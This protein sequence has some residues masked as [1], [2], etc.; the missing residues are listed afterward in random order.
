MRKRSLRNQLIV[1]MLL[2]SIVPLLLIAILSLS[3]FPGVLGEQ[4]SN[5]L[6][7]VREIK[8]KQLENY[9]QSIKYQS[10]YFV[11][12]QRAA[13][14]SPENTPVLSYIQD[15]GRAVALLFEENEQTALGQLFE[16]DKHSLSGLANSEFYYFVHEHLHPRIQPF[17]DKMG[18]N[19]IYLSSSSGLIIYAVTK[20]DYF[21][22][23]VSALAGHCCG[24]FNAFQQA[25]EHPVN[26]T[27]VEPIYFTDFSV[28]ENARQALSYISIPI[29]EYG[30][31]TGVIIYEIAL[32]DINAIMAE[33]SGLGHS[34]E[35]YLVA[36]DHSLRS[37]VVGKDHVNSVY[38]SLAKGS[39]IS[40]TSASI[41]AALAGQSDVQTSRSYAQQEVLSAYAPVK[42]FDAQWALV[43]DMPSVEAY[44]YIRSFKV[45]VILITTALGL[46]IVV[47][48]LSFA[49][50]I[51]N[52]ITTLT[53]WSE[54]IT[55]GDLSPTLGIQRDDELGRLA[56]SFTVMKEAIR[57][58]IAEI[59]SQNLALKQLDKLKDNILANTSH[60]LRTPLNAI[61][62]LAE[63][64][65][66]QVSE[67]RSLST[68]RRSL[69]T[70]IRSGHR[71]NHLLNDILDVASLK[72]GNI[73]LTLDVLNL[74]QIVDIDRSISTALVGDKAIDIINNVPETLAVLADQNRLLQILHNLVCNAIKF[75]D[76]GTVEISAHQVGERVEITVS[77]TGCGIAKND[78]QSIFKPFE[79]SAATV[80]RSARG[81]GLGLAIAQQL[82]ELHGGSIRVESQLGVGSRFTFSL[83][84]SH[85]RPKH[86]ITMSALSDDRC[87]TENSATECVT[88]D[89]PQVSTPGLTLLAV[90]DEPVNL[91]VLK[92][93]L[94]PDQFTV[95]TAANAEQALS[96]MDN[97]QPDIMLLDVMMP[98]MN[99]YQLCEIIRQQYDCHQLPIIFLTARNQVGDL[100]KAFRVGGNDFLAKPYSRDE[101]MAR[102]M[103]Q[104][105]LY[106]NHSR[107]QKLHDFSGRI[108]QMQSH[109]Q[110]L[111]EASALIRA[112]ALVSDVAVYFDGE[113]LTG[114]ES[115][116]L[117]YSDDD[118]TLG[119]RR[120]HRSERECFYAKVT[121]F[122]TL[123]V[124]CDM[125]YCEA[126]LNNVLDQLRLLTQQV[127]KITHSTHS[128][129]LHKEVLPFLH[130]I[131][132]IKA[133]RNYCSLFRDNEGRVKEYLLRIP[134]KKIIFPL[135]DSQLIQVHRSYAV[136]PGKIQAVYGNS[137]RIELE[138]GASVPV[139]R[140]YINEI[141]RRHSDCYYTHEASDSNLIQ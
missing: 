12:A 1:V 114:N 130:N 124:R 103:S 49:R 4:V 70:I 104:A 125:K 51:A 40:Y 69:L 121:D 61:I 140:K 26:S 71:L 28:K 112:D 90:D 31:F 98:G 20:N 37:N 138:N 86:H 115:G 15:F 67:G 117:R 85:R 64:L 78:L 139:S 109:E 118:G 3:Y 24:I 132:Y 13:S 5:Q 87:V 56:S 10:Q 77:D 100:V 42:V 79:Q 116:Y 60:E 110:I 33:R 48:A 141:K 9:F 126:W 89:I 123:I 6:I 50:L 7:S 73:A 27:D 102:L 38:H 129:I 93:H 53:Q 32:N 135:D 92:S 95:L 46:L 75:T 21:G 137:Q 134:F 80:S 63:S 84:Y 97:T 25:K 55:S 82:A 8:K 18:F 120:E 94:C 119:I 74:R 65:V 54:A 128:N 34:G 96:L 14:M 101:L 88:D 16:T 107:L 47:A 19:N 99:G 113:L 62:G 30:V 66:G 72:H 81:T 131:Y 17:S 83:A 52:P 44:Q 2:L 111:T 58:K 22:K 29:Y 127:K 57:E 108:A 43:A 91:Q 68:Q 106:V 45:M 23:N 41:D 122:Y 76:S 105:L 133:E 11:G 36:G 59:E 136:N 35:T 39:A